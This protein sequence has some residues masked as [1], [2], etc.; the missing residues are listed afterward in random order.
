[1]KKIFA[2]AVALSALGLIMAGCQSGDAGG[3]DTP[4]ETAGGTTGTE[5]GK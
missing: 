2:I 1:M 5:E 4:K 3:G